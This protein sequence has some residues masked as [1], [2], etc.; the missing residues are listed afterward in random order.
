MTTGN[1]NEAI[2]Q[3]A[4]LFPKCFFVR[5]YQRQP[6]KIGI[7]DDLL[8]LVPFAADDLKALLRRYTNADGYLRACGEGAYRIDLE[9]NAAGTVDAKQAAFAQKVLA[10]RERGRLKKKEN[11]AK[12]KAT[13]RT[14]TTPAMGGQPGQPTEL[15][16]P[17]T[18]SSDNSS[19]AQQPPSTPRRLGC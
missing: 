8:P 1:G 3:L 10:Q 12:E 19:P 11:R 2:A 16:R 13:Q 17:V 18:P 9:G 5:G 15:G 14:Q 4:E 7:F 6:L